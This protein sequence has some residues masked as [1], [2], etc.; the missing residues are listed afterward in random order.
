MEKAEIIYLHAN[1][2][3]LTK[4]GKKL[5]PEDIVNGFWDYINYCKGYCIDH[6]TN[7]G[8]IL[9]VNKPRVPNKGGFFS[10]LKITSQT[11][12]NYG[13]EDAYKNYHG[14]V[15]E[16]NDFF[17]N[18]KMDA[19]INGDGNTTGL[20]FDLKVH[21]GLNERQIIENN[22][23]ITGININVLPAPALP[24]SEADIDLS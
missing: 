10:Y 1:G 18:E 24:R 19:L 4:K 16:I 2:G 5:Q 11:W 12:L 6:P 3:Y 17:F 20:I 22:S 8:M 21:H 23:T 9:K 15:S 7:S 13:K 14:I